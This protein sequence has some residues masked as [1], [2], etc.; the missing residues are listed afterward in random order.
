MVTITYN[1]VMHVTMVTLYSVVMPVAMV[2]YI[3]YNMVMLV[4][5][6]TST[7]MHGDHGDACG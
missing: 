5:M 6:V 2:S 4:T 3:I 1:M 7:Y